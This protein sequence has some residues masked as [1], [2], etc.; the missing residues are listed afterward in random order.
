M[1]EVHQLSEDLA[2]VRGAVQRRDSRRPDMLGVYAP[3]AVY[4]LV[5][6]TL[7]DFRPDIANF[8]F[9]FGW[10]PACLV[11][12]L[13]TRK[14]KALG[15]IGSDRQYSRN[16]AL[17]WYGGIV[18]A[19]ATSIALSNVIPGLRGTPSGQITVCM[20]GLVY[21]FGGVHFDRRFLVLGPV[22][23]VCAIFVGFIPKLPW[24]TLGIVIATGLVVPSFFKRKVHVEA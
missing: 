15:E 23:I 21:F 24:T 7:L 6:Y 3:W 9:A 18:L 13:F 5:G 1:S 16:V 14:L 4:V 20:V 2:F 11:A 12:Y 19:L 10:I 22:M 17:H 8:V